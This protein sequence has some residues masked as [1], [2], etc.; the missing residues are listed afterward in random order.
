MISF[1]QWLNLKESSPHTRTRREVAAGLKP[2][3]AL[4]SLHG[5]STASPNEVKSVNRQKKKKKSVFRASKG[6]RK[7]GP[8]TKN[9]EVDNWI[10]EVEELKKSLADL[11]AAIE[12]KQSELKKKKPEKEK[13]K[14][15]KKPEEDEDGKKPDD[16]ELNKSA[17]K[18]DKPED[19]PDGKRPTGKK[20][21]LKEFKD[22][23]KNLKS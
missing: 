15:E 19:K 14:L 5:R 2:L 7:I 10:K 6:H 22:F 3:A 11:R 23:K 8:K 18:E 12:K 1:S 21:A 20:S 17:D 13:T 16:K 4:G 9:L